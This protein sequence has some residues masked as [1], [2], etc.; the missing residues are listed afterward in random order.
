MPSRSLAKWQASSSL[1]LDQIAAAPAAVGGT[2]RG[3]RY[4]TQQLNHAYI[5]L[6]A[7][8]FQGFCRDLHSEAVDHLVGPLQPTDLRTHML[9]IRLT[10]GRQLDA[11]NAQ[12]SSIGADFGRLQMDFWPL[13]L[14]RDRRNADRRAALEELNRWRNAIAHHDFDPAELG[15]RTAARLVDVRRFR[16]AC[17]ALAVEFDLT[18]RDHLAAILRTPPW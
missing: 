14:A 15:G 8:Q 12:P 7:S 13:V 4:A 18:I 2:G 3:R 9:R 6:L 1:E 10:E 11:K 17:D 16:A 5:V